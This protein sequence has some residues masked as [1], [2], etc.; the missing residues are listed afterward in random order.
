MF[1]Y[2]K[3][4]PPCFLS[5]FAF[6]HSGNFHADLVPAD[7]TT[8]VEAQCSITIK[9]DKRIIQSNGIPEH[10]VGSFPNRRNPN[11]ITEQSY[12]YQVPLHP[13]VAN[14]A[15]P[16]VRQP[17]GVALN[18]VPFDPGTAEYYKRESDSDWN[19]EALSGEI[20]FGLDENHAHVQPSGAYHYHGLPTALFDK[21]SEGKQ[22]MTL[23]GWAA[24]GFPVYGIYGYTTADDASSG[25]QV[26]KSSY[27]IK[28]GKRPFG[29]DSPGGNYDGTFTIDYEFVKGR[30]DLDECGGRFGVTPDFPEGTYY[31]ILTEDYPFIPRMFRGTPDRSFERRHRGGGSRTERGGPPPPRDP[32]V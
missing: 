6:A 25:V 26:L 32:Q 31:Y 14:T 27:R 13:A 24:D 28:K 20:D 7:Q 29:S 1:T 9:G 3:L 5:I 2:L 18:G 12:L 8:K 10:Q 16:L 17:F 19:Y 21:L 30:G 23:L 22:R 11:A 15:T 4:L